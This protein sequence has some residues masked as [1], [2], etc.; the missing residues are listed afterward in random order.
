MASLRYQVESLKQL[1]GALFTAAGMDDDKAR[2]VARLLV[3]GDMIGQRTH[4]MA[5]CPQYIDQ[6]E[7]GLMTTSGEPEVVR[8]SGAVFVWDG[9]YLPGPWLVSRALDTAS[10]RVAGHGVV[11]CVIRRSHHIACLASLI[12]Q[13]TDRGL[14][15]ILASSDPASGFIAPFGGKEPLLTPNPIAIGYP[16]SRAPVWIDVSTSIT[17]VAMARQKSAANT[18]FDH[19]WL[20]DGAGRPT[21]DPHVLDPGAGGTLLAVGGREYGHKGFGL[22]LMVEMLTQGLAGFGRQ[23]SEKRWGANVFLQVL[24]PGA[25]AGRE[26]FLRQMDYLTDRCHANAPIDPAHPVRMPGEMAQ[27]R[28]KAAEESG[29]ELAPS[30]LEALSAT[31]KRYNIALPDPL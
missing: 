26:S 21:D 29:V 31:A 20:M 12:K 18:S 15:A 1:A 4:G 11:T 27:K 13:A 16:D 24:D 3:A 14:V 2:C 25:F 7:K 8:D 30:V 19:R 10:E 5:L 9:N 23:D 28:I 17:T 6:I 22:S